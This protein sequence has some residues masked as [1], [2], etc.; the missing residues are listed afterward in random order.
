MP[1]LQHALAVETGDHTLDEDN[2]PDEGLLFSVCNGLLI[3]EGGFLSLVH[4]TLQEYLELKAE[5]LFPEAQADIVRTCLTYLSF[6]DFEEGPCCLGD[7]EFEARLRRWPLLRYAVFKWGYYAR[8]TVE[9]PCKD[10]IMSFL[11]N[12]AVLSASV[13]VLCVRES[14]GF[15][16]SNHFPKNV[17]PIWLA[18]F[19]G[20]EVIVLCLLAKDK[21]SVLS[22]TTWGDTA[23]HRAAG[24][25]QEKV[26]QLLLEHGADSCAKDRAGNAPLHLATLFLNDI[27]AHD[28]RT[29]TL[30][31]NRGRMAQQVRTLNYSLAVKQSLLNHGADVNSINLRGESALHLAVCDGHSSLSRLLLESG[32][33]VTQKDRNG[34]APLAIASQCGLQEVTRVLVEH[35]LQRQI[36]MGILDDALQRA[37]YKDHLSLLK[38]L[39]SK[40]PKL[41][42]TDREGRNLLH[43]SA[44]RGSLKCLKHLADLGFDLHALDKQRRTCLHHAAAGSGEAIE[45]LLDYGLD[46]KQ[47]DVDGWTPLIWAARGGLSPCVRQLLKVSAPYEDGKD[48]MPYAVAIFHEDIKAAALLKPLDQALPRS[49]EFQHLGKSLLHPDICCDGCDLVSDTQVVVFSSDLRLTFSKPVYGSRYRCSVCPNFDYCFK[50]ILSAKITHPSHKFKSVYW[51]GGDPDAQKIDRSDVMKEIKLREAMLTAGVVSA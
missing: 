30:L 37:A 5:T 13:Q 19:W 45:F 29:S 24:C 32:A 9:E 22:K 49:L 42:P 21:R 36:Q 2:I 46:P 27:F 50:C 12:N 40:A 23:L 18:S 11:S 39:I 15:G 20:L 34:L 17:P 35:D 41:L 4:Y 43:M 33:D 51:G 26:V 25:G 7:Q 6:D 47:P 38:I 28:I 48:W 14:M 10:L 16:Y 31:E 3:H 1:E 44:F 8:E